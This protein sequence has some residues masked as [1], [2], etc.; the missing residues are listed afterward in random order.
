MVGTLDANYLF[1]EQKTI[2]FLLLC[3]FVIQCSNSTYKICSNMGFTH[4]FSAFWNYD[5]KCILFLLLGFLGL[6]LNI[7]YMI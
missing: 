3:C 2:F 4:V 1:N 7:L 6:R 5:D